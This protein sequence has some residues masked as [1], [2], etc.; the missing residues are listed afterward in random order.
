[1]AEFCTKCNNEMFGSEIVADINVSKL[2]EDLDEGYMKDG[3]I[4]EGCGLVMIAKI[5]NHLLVGKVKYSEDG[6]RD[7]SEDF[8]NI[9]DYENFK[10]K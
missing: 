2:F 9:G 4:C 7:Y 1:M 8:E 10:Q 3:F 5:G 6:V